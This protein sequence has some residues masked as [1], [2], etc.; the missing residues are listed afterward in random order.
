MRFPMFARARSALHRYKQNEEGTAIVLLGF[1]VF[2]LVGAAGLAFD[3]GRGYMLNA[4]LSQAVDAAALAGGRSLSIGS[5]GDYKAVIKKYFKANLPDGYM[6]AEI[7]DPIIELKGD[8]DEIEVVATAT[9]PTT[10]MRVLGS[11]SMK[12]DARA[13]VHRAVK[14]LEV[15]LVLDNSGSMSGGKM[16]DLKDSS[17]LLVD[18]LYGDNDVVE[19]LY[20]SIVPFTGR[21]NLKGHTQVHPV[22][23]PPPSS[24]YICLDMRGGNFAENDAPPVTNPFDHFSNGP[25][26]W[27]ENSTKHKDRV[28]PK[29]AILPLVQSKSTVKTAINGMKA[30]GCTRYD[31]GTVWGWRN[32]SPRWQGLWGG[33]P[34]SLPLAYEEAD[35]EKAII[36]MTD[37]ANTPDCL[38]DVQTEEQTEQAF[39]RI[40]ADMKANG[41]VIYT[42]TFKLDDP[43]TNDLFRTCASGQER[44]FKSPSSD[45]L[46]TAFTTIANDLSTLRLSQ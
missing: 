7:P 19:D 5:G 32:I 22:E 15:A 24:T 8:G 30:K 13:V 18:I 42:I 27:E 41:I 26:T 9:V 45:A 28:C 14:G 3:A 6:G 38:K 20:V 46:E 33:S 1:A 36:I 10:L 21:T 16:T 17:K 4:R 44:Y 34:G 12:I 35:M 2:V 31:I 29:A 11:K 37:G 40:C 43:D 25:Y 23:P 39:S